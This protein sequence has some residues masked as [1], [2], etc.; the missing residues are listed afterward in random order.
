LIENGVE[1][2]CSHDYGYNALPVLCRN[3]NK[4]NLFD[5]VKLLIENGIEVHCNPNN[6]GNALNIVCRYY[7]K[8]NMIDIIQLLSSKKGGEHNG[9]LPNGSSTKATK[10]RHD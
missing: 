6:D 1:I 10:R 5:V 4:D 7:K 3:Y 8:D 2:N 9:N